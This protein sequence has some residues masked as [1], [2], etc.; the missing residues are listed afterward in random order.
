MFLR[1]HVTNDIL[2]QS[3]DIWSVL[4]AEIG[5]SMVAA[6]ARYTADLQSARLGQR[7]SGLLAVNQ[8]ASE[9]GR[10]ACWQSTN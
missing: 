2:W 7:Q 5:T 4:P 3:Q 10:A 1:Y 6:I 8:P 9:S